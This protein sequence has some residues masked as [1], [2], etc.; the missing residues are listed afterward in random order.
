MAPCFLWSQTMNAY[1]INNLDNG[2]GWNEN[3]VWQEVHGNTWGVD[4]GA[5]NDASTCSY[6]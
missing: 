5:V 1:Y 3:I 6:T 2:Q 4:S